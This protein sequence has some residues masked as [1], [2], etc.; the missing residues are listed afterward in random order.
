MPE[1]ESSVVVAL[2]SGVSQEG[3]VTLLVHVQHG[4]VVIF[5]TFQTEFFRGAD[6]A[7]VAS[8]T[9][10]V[11]LSQTVGEA[12][13]QSGGGCDCPQTAAIIRLGEEGQIAS[14]ICDEIDGGPAGYNRLQSRAIQNDEAEIDKPGISYRLPLR[15]CGNHILWQPQASELAQVLAHKFDCEAR[16]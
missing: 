6:R 3:H 9:G 13:F 8:I 2:Y 16:R 4:L 14:S 1:T 10:P 12:I 7:G 5:D 15:Q 11:D